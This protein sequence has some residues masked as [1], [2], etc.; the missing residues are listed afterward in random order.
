MKNFDN[1]SNQI[2]SFVIR[3]LEINDLIWIDDCWFKCSYNSNREVEIIHLDS[4]YRG[5]K[6]G[7]LKMSNVIAS[8]IMAAGFLKANL[9][10]IYINQVENKRAKTIFYIHFKDLLDN[11]IQKNKLEQDPKNEIEIIEQSDNIQTL[12]STTGSIIS[13]QAQLAQMLQ[14]PKQEYHFTFKIFPMLDR[15]NAMKILIEGVNFENKDEVNFL[16]KNLNKNDDKDTM[17][18]IFENAQAS[19]NCKAI[20]SDN[21]DTIKL[22]NETEL[23]YADLTKS[24]FDCII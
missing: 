23:D 18:F 24:Y 2:F 5:E 10:Q 19:S 7:P 3:D 20:F 14:C 9:Q 13:T 6:V 16:L 12:L 15:F 1:K 8:A 17:C 22:Q 21:P 4:I 11:A